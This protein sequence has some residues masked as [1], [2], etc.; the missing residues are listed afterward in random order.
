L[1]VNSSSEIRHLLFFLSC[2]ILVGWAFDML[3]WLLVLIL[4]GY[5]IWNLHQLSRL[6]NWLKDSNPTDPP[7]SYGLWGAVF[8]D[9][10]TLQQDQ[11]KYRAKL[12]K[13]IKRFRDSTYALA[14][15]FVMLDQD[16]ILDW[17]NP[18]AERLLGLQRPADHGQLITNLIREPRFKAYVN[19][20]HFE[21]PLE[22]SSPVNNWA[23]LEY[24]I[25][26]FGKKDV[27]VIVRDITEF[28]HLEQVRT[29]FIG[30]ISHE[31][32]T[33]LT[34][35]SGYL[36]SM[37]ANSETFPPPWIRAI[38]QAQVQ[39]ERLKS[40]VRDL[41]VL[42]KVESQSSAAQQT[43]VNMQQL[44]LEIQSDLEPI[45]NKK[46]HRFEIIVNSEYLLAGD[47]SDF[48]NLASNL[49]V[50]A[51]NYSPEGS[52]IQA[53]WSCD[54]AGGYLSIVDNGQGIDPIELPRITERFYRV[55]RDRSRDSGGTGLGLS[56]VKHLLINYGGNLKIESRPGVGSTFTCEFPRQRLRKLEFSPTSV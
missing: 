40:L 3:A 46:K 56:I 35:I 42:S 19:Q 14:D 12:K 36:E 24:Q 44:L 20:G 22:M 50:N 54:D 29:D 21:K 25:T 38:Q 28:K 47:R 23:T 55:E 13:V 48:Y 1:I 37:E 9:I 10:Y 32:R 16:G 11:F 33:P 43:P 30:N 7:A 41:L 6:H 53:S 31:L 17:W 34:V 52:Q 5:V 26:R 18:A 51:C 2:G 8:D 4:S 49:L 39:T 27:L 15:G 45:L